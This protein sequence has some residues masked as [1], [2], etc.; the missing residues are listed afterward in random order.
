MVAA[1]LF[2]ALRL[3]AVGSDPASPDDGDVWYRTDTDKA[4]LR[5]NGATVSLAD[6]TRQVVSGDG[7]TGGGDL[8]AD[9]TLA[10]GA[11]AGIVVSADAVEAWVPLVN[12]LAADTGTINSTTTVAIATVTLLRTGTYYFEADIN[13][14]GNGTTCGIGLA[15]VGSAVTSAWR[16][17]CQLNIGVATSN[18]G[19]NA[20]GTTISSIGSAVGV[21]VGPTGTVVTATGIRIAGTFTCTTVGTFA[22]ALSRINGTGTFVG[23]SGSVMIVHQSA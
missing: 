8:S 5:A 13:L 10:V 21:N 22:V 19:V 17:T 14:V 18:A 4:R 11:G 9:R 3:W 2:R 23:K 16:W 15:I 12:Q 6:E 1:R 7:L 20:N